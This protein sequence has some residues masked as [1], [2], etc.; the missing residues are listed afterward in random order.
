MS[1][2]AWST[3]RGSLTCEEAGRD[4]LVM[5]LAGHLEASLAE[6]LQKAVEAALTGGARPHLFLDAA[7]ATGL[8]PQFRIQLTPWH[9]RI[10]ARVQSQNVL[11]KSKIIAMAISVM[12]MSAGHVLKP[13]NQRREFEAALTFAR[14]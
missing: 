6:H 8:D 4:V 9:K 1:K 3:E 12:N 13:Y 11:V 14:K 10:S 2:Q 5:K 7:D